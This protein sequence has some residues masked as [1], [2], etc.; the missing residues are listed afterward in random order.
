MHAHT[1]AGKR[2]GKM[3]RGRGRSMLPT[4]E[5]ARCWN[6]SQ[7]LGIMTWAEGLTDWATQTL[8]KWVISV[9]TLHFRVAKKSVLQRCGSFSSIPFTQPYKKYVSPFYRLVLAWDCAVLCLSPGSSFLEVRRCFLGGLGMTGNATSLPV[10]NPVL[11]L[12]AWWT[13]SAGWHCGSQQGV[14]EAKASEVHGSQFTQLKSRTT[15]FM[16]N[17]SAW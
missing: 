5:G 4:E 14:N 7:D 6:P 17:L 16:S 13:S 2:W 10:A 1:W 12:L 3:S 15:N 8:L 9:T 11:S